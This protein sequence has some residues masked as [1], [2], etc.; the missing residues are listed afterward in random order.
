MWRVECRVRRWGGG[1]V[2]VEWGGGVWRGECRVGK[3]GVEGGV[4]VGCEG[5]SV[6]CGGVRQMGMW[7]QHLHTTAV[8]GGVSHSG[9]VVHASH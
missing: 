8:A 9:V 5:V 3:W 4:E 6:G 2:S 7:H 1:G